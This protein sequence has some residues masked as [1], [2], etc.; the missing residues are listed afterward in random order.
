MTENL[1]APER[2]S[3]LLLVFRNL[4]TVLCRKANLKLPELAI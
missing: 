2:G 1:L 4:D 3:P